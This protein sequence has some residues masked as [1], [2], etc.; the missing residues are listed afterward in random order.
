M[1][2][3]KKTSS[4]LIILYLFLTVFPNVSSAH[5]YIIE[6]TPA[7]NETLKTAPNEVKIQFD[8]SI[9]PKFNSII[10][11]DSNGKQV[12]KKNGAIDSK[13]PSILKASL[14]KNLPGG[15]Y[16]IRWKVI[17]NDGH[18]VQ[19]VIPF[20]IGTGTV[21][22]PSSVTETK[23][24]T[25][26]L[27]LVIIRWLQY[28]GIACYVGLSF[29][30]LVVAPKEVV[31]VRSIEKT[32]FKFIWS[33]Y[34]L[35]LL[36]NLFSLPLQATILLGSSWSEVFS[37]D[38]LGQ[39]LAYTLFG[40]MWIIQMGILLTLAFTTYFLTKADA[41]KQLFS[42]A[43]FILGFGMVV[44]KAFTSHAASQANQFLS[45]SMDALHL[46]AASVWIGCLI[47]LVVL[48]PLLKN[49][50]MK[51]SYVNTFQRFSNWGISLVLLLTATGIFNGFQYIPTISSIFHTDYGR[52]LLAKVILFIIMLIF[53][54]VNNF[55]GKKAKEKG[56][57]S[58]L[59][60]ELIVGMVIIVMTVILTNL[61]TA[62]SAPGPFNEKKTV[63]HGNSI[64][65]QVGPNVIGE[66]NY[67]ITLK[68]R[69]G[70]P[71]KDIA[72]ITL[73]FTHNDM[74]MGEDTITLAKTADGQYTAKGMN[75]NMAGKWNVHVHVLT[76]NLENIDTDFQCIVGS[77]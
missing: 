21:Q 44:T 61:P 35:L 5:A 8:E 45:I 50:E 60:G 28:L 63:N 68:N 69:K 13:K 32:L 74:N 4:F 29:F 66:N 77:R 42:W 10:V 9:Q 43:C 2:K 17:S 64:S 22:N 6:S 51:Q 34:A 38:A 59:W 58:S 18:P 76:K 54:A 47:G 16:R 1:K 20:Q 49:S 39:V 25:P 57:V 26:H 40:K 31:E 33:G 11:T 67:E 73:T 48:L 14:K 36:S 65:F 3:I 24:Y 23:G 46:L 72:Q 62:M 53:A 41:R 52:V 71:L 56:V 12:D 15:T 55:K 19:G 70:E 27:D 75:F 7:E 37:S 30:Y